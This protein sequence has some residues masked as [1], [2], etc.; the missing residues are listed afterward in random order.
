MEN[1]EQYSQIQ[2]NQLEYLANQASKHP[3][4]QLVPKV[5]QNQDILTVQPRFEPSA[6]RY[7]TTPGAKW[8]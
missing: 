8:S 6:V 3:T 4:Y 2:A 7:N 5:S 1:V